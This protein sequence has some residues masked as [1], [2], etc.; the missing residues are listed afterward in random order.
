MIIRKCQEDGRLFA[1]NDMDAA[2]KRKL[3]RFRTMHVFGHIT[4]TTHTH[5]CTFGH[6]V[7]RPESHQVELPGTAFFDVWS[8]GQKVIQSSLLG[9]ARKSSNRIPGF[10]DVWSQGQKVIKSQEAFHGYQGIFLCI[11]LRF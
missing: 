9:L 8:Q 10:V 2:A 6:C 3:S 1:C 7:P 11:S 5:I 4:T